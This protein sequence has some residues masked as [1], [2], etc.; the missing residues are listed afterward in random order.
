MKIEQLFF[1]LIRF[2]L[3]NVDSLSQIPKPKEWKMLYEMAKKQSLVGICFAGVQKTL[4]DSPLKGEDPS[5]IGMPE[6]LYLTWMGIAATIQQRNEVVNR[7][8]VELQR[9]LANDGFQSCILK[10]QGVAMVYPEHLRGLRQSGDIDV[11]AKPMEAVADGRMVMTAEERRK[12]ICE[13]CMRLDS[14][15][16]RTKEG[17]LHTSVKVF[18]DTDMEW[19]FTPSFMSSPSANKRLQKWFEEQWVECVKTNEERK[20]KDANLDLN[21][22]V[23]LNLNDNPSINHGST[24]LTTS[25]P[26]SINLQT[27]SVEFNLVYLLHHIFRHYLYEGVGLRQVMDYYFVL[28]AY[29][30]ERGT[31]NEGRKTVFRDS[32][33][34]NSSLVEDD[35]LRL[36]K[37]LGMEKFAG[38]LMWVIAH[39]FGNED[40]GFDKLTNR[41]KNENHKPSSLNLLCEPDEKRG[42]RLLEVIME[43]GNFG[44]STERY[45]VTGWDKPW[46]RL[47][48]Y[49]R[50]NW[51]ML[52]DYPDEI[53]WNMIK[54]FKI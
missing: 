53:I 50:R 33:V 25:A 15:Y 22:N 12:R 34:N 42:R 28:Q 21:A 44:H 6:M 37:R 47:S 23:T 38:A 1:E 8:C 48:R 36:I 14:Q 32:F 46:N 18:P 54:K 16:D 52:W 5:V 40:D 4:S 24:K 30:E 13:C 2:A 49:I 43:G 51:F 41:D 20:T 31:K 17:E 39:V 45:K 26:S 9:K 3:G 11:W 27:P 10:G 29:Y 19:H 35:S 7:Q